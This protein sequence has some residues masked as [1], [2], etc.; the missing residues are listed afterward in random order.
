MIGLPCADLLR[1]SHGQG[2]PHRTTRHSMEPPAARETSHRADA[3][4]LRRPVRTARGMRLLSVL[5]TVDIRPHCHEKRK[6]LSVE[7][8]TKE[9][10]LP[11]ELRQ[12]PATRC[13]AFSK[14]LVFA[15]VG[16][17]VAKDRQHRPDRRRRNKRTDRVR[18]R[19]DPLE[20]PI[21]LFVDPE[22][23]LVAPHFPN[24]LDRDGR[25]GPLAATHQEVVRFKAQSG[26]DL[27]G[28]DHGAEQRE[29]NKLTNT[30]PANLSTPAAT[31][32]N[33]A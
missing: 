29:A 32:D 5:I 25:I 1:R 20:H 11:R 4:A 12:L 9:L 13:G 26:R 6:E 8:P 23:W 16:V 28:R 18:V 2:A 19:T 14:N 10:V 21:D 17:K 30:H 33:T 31:I 27:L 15:I 7:M 22:P 3:R 24:V